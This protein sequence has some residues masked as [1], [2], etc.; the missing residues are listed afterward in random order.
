MKRREV[1]AGVGSLA[2]LGA[3]AYAVFGRPGQATGDRIEPVT[4]DTL[5]VAGSPGTELGV[6]FEGTV[7]VVDLFATTC[8]ACPDHID[9]LAAARE[10]LDGDVRF[11]S[12]TNQIVDDRQ[13]RSYFR[14]WWRSHGADWPVGFDDEGALTTAFDVPARPFTG[15]VAPDLTIAWAEAGQTDVE[16]VVNQVQTVLEREE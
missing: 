9:T 8:A 3:G 11:V 4:I 6:P 7:T 12:V 1:L 2:A 10:Q 5:D 14:D 15:I 13:P 16:T